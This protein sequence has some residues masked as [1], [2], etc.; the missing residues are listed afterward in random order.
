MFSHQFLVVPECPTPLLGKE[1]SLALKL[2]S[3]CS[4]DRRCFETFSWGQTNYFY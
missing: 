2:C 4:P 3:Y 1:L